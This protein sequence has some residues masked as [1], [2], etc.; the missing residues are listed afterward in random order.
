MLK[1]IFEP[2][3]IAFIGATDRKG[4]VGKGICKNLLEGEKERKVFFVNPYRKRIFGRKVYP[5]ILSI[6]EFIDLAIIAIPAPLVLS[7][8]KECIQKKVKGI[9][10]ISA[11]F[12]E[13]GKEG[14]VREKEILKILKN[15]S[16]RLIGPN[17]L[18]IIRPSKKLNASFAPALPKKGKIAFLSQSGA[19][20]DS[21]IDD[22]LEKNYGFS[23]LISYGNEAD[24]TVCDFLEYLKNDKETKVIAIYLENLKD[25]KRFIEVAKIVNKKKPIVILKG[26]KSLKGRKAA[27]SHTGRLISQPQIYSVAF[28]KAGIFEV[29]KIDDLLEVSIALASERFCKNGIG[30]I[31]NGGGVGVLTAD[32]S[33]RLGVNLSR[34]SSKTLNFLRKN[35]ALK[36]KV[37][38]GNPLDI[39]GDALS[40]RYKIA[41]EGMLSQKDIYGLIVIQT[42]QIMTEVEKNAKVIVDLQK[43]YPKKPIIVVPV[44]GKF[45]K[46]G[47]EILRKNSIL[48]YP[49]PYQ[50][51]LAMRSLIH[52]KN[53]VQ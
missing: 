44:G 27:L 3:K 9:I 28:K 23:V 26:G 31:T 53:V 49:E 5:S 35:L 47:V 34:L 15:T 4:S 41:I 8:V 43:K 13:I 11:G 17:C 20:I 39:L 6:P 45:T 40:E 48:C 24:L 22:S 30:I 21:V 50:A 51:V 2:N 14:E 25:G 16:T 33:E 36:G 18:G 46:R 38:F 19:L 52:A 12:A 7:V 29:E 42:L 32:W 1:S 10:I 37:S